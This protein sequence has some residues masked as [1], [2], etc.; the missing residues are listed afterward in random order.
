[1]AIDRACPTQLH[2]HASRPPVLLA[3]PGF[4]RLSR[5]TIRHQPPG[6]P[7]C[8]TVH[9]SEHHSEPSEQPTG[10]NSKAERVPELQPGGGILVG[11]VAVAR[12]V[13]QAIVNL[14]GRRSRSRG[15][16]GR[17]RGGRVDA[18]GALRTAGVLLAAVRGA[19]VVTAARRDALGAPG[20]ADVVGEGQ[21][22]LGDVG[23]LA[24]AA[25]AAVG[26]RLLGGLSARRRVTQ[27]NDGEVHTYRVAGVDLRGA[28]RRLKA[29]G[30]AATPLIVA[31][32]LCVAC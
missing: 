9:P 21:G 18:G 23:L 14:V 31:P 8:R 19:L 28:G 25:D 30:R 26:E 4:P 29:D 12:A 20:D 6:F 11:V 10:H 24:V 3:D 2:Q 15:Q 7:T 17:C 27:S 32:R 1:M 22:V 16:S 5:L 13:G